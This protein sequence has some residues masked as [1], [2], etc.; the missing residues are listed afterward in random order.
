MLL[1]KMDTNNHDTYWLERSIKLADE[2]VKSVIESD[3]GVFWESN[4]LTDDYSLY[5]YRSENL[6]SGV[7][8]PILYLIAL[9]KAL[10]KEEYYETILK[11]TDW[12]YN[13]CKKTPA[14]N[15]SFMNGRMGAVYTLLQ[16]YELTTDRKYAD[17]AHELYKDCKLPLAV[18]SDM[19]FETGS[20]GTLF[21][22]IHLYTACE[23]KET[24][25]QLT[26][27]TANVY[28]LALIE[29]AKEHQNT[30]SRNDLA[31]ILHT[32]SHHSLIEKNSLGSNL[33]AKLEASVKSLSKVELHN[34]P[35]MKWNCIYWNLLKSFRILKVSGREVEKPDLIASEEQLK[36]L[37]SNLPE[38]FILDEDTIGRGFAYLYLWNPASFADTFTPDLK[39]TATKALSVNQQRIAEKFLIHQFPETIKALQQTANDLWQ[40]WILSRTFNAKLQDEFYQWINS[41]SQEN[42]VYKDRLLLDEEINRLKNKIQNYDYLHI[43]NSLNIRNSKSSFQFALRN[44]NYKYY[45]KLSDYI[46]CLKLHSLPS[47]TAEATSD[48]F[49][50]LYCHR[51]KI[52][53]RPI[54]KFEYLVLNS[55]KEDTNVLLR[56]FTAKIEAMF[57]CPTKEDLQKVR[58]TLAVLLNRLVLHGFISITQ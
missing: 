7:P 8:G 35:Q 26:N 29:E 48:S 28:A 2:L 43:K 31:F 54:S 20:L 47:D 17:Q 49:V 16:V 4:G 3:S 19:S 45:V 38:P 21:V 25:E 58:K 5:Q 42:P 12:L 23:D 36:V 50:I 51:N 15:L 1:T 52:S 18:E 46:Q 33:S 14:D 40:E 32:L 56:A 53:Y 22:L 39:L 41:L 10:K 13:Y 9:Y 44:P 34:E 57:N 37:D 30:E 27:L 24:G 11:A 55:L 6:H